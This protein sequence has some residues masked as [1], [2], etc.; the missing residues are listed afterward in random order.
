MPCTTVDYSLTPPAG[1]F[2]VI[3]F[4]VVGSTESVEKLSTVF[5]DIATQDVDFVTILGEN[6]ETTETVSVD[7]LDRVIRNYDLP[8][9]FVA[10]ERSVAVEDGAYVVRRLGP[11][12]YSFSLGPARFASFFS[13]TRDLGQNGLTRLENVLRQ[14]SRANQGPFFAFTHTAPLDPNGVR[15]FGFRNRIEGAQTMSLLNQFDV[16]YLFAGRINGS[17]QEMFGPTEVMI[18]SAADSS[19]RSANEYLLVR[20]DSSG[21]G[22]RVINGVGVS[23]TKRSL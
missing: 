12:E 4:A 9:V 13:A 7:A 19:L 5:D 1:S 18:T 23:V 10:G 8:V 16:N 6:V 20:V 17:D 22:D 21:Q 14:A 3:T 2:D 11:H 15:D